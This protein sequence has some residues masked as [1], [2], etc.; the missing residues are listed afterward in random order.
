MASISQIIRRLVA[1]NAIE[2]QTASRPCAASAKNGDERLLRKNRLLWQPGCYLLSYIPPEPSGEGREA[3]GEILRL[4]HFMA[5]KTNVYVD[6]F[7]LYDGC[8]RKTP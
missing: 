4:L 1:V 6:A 2:K 8:L 7:N 3:A 5:L